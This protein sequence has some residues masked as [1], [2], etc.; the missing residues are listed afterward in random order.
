MTKQVYIIGAG[1]FAK[2]VYLILK[3]VF[4]NG[5]LNV[6]GFITHNSEVDTVKIGIKEFPIVNESEFL[7][8]VKPSQEIQLY[9][10]IGDPAVIKKVAGKFSAYN[11][12]NLIS[13]CVEIDES[14]Q[15]GRGNILTKG[16]NFTIDISVGSFNIFNL[17]TTFGHDT[18]IGN[19]NVF[20]PGASIS[21]GVQIGNGNLIGTGATI[22]QNLSIG[23]GNVIGG[24]GLL[25]KNI[26][27]SKVMVGV[28][29]KELIK[30]TE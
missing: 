5:E 22:L 12:P 20:N 14:V 18:Q 25:S 3:R 6:L 15:L 4:K 29:C 27:D 28:P 23:D 10:G 19:Y 30:K 11:F 7:K 1:G 8:T 21:G 17:N 16:A 26:Q 2:E 9:I 24:N 13:P